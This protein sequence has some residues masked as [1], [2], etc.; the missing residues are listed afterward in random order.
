MAFRKNKKFI[1]PRYFMDEKTEVVKEGFTTSGPDPSKAL[2]QEQI[3]AIIKMKG[4][5]WWEKAGPHINGEN[6]F[7]YLD[8][9]YASEIMSIKEELN[10][11]MDDPDPGDQAEYEAL[12][13]QIGTS[14]DFNRLLTLRNRLDVEHEEMLRRLFDASH[15]VGDEPQQD[16]ADQEEE[17]PLRIGTPKEN[18]WALKKRLGFDGTVHDRL[19][20]PRHRKDK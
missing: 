19:G 12:I 17:E 13:T 15:G 20:G 7:D 14:E 1:D 16:Q 5:D 4:M 3:A 8:P 11:F 6:I 18:P 9:A 2:S 10:E